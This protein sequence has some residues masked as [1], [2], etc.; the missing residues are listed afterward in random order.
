MNETELRAYAKINLSLTVTGRRENGYHNIR[1]LMQG[2]GLFDVIKLTKCPRNATKY[3]LPHCT[4]GGV[5]VYL[6]TDTETIPVDMSN[7]AFRGAAAVIDAY[8][9]QIQDDLMISIDKR[10]P[11]AAGIAGGSGNAAVCMLGLN[12][13][14][15][16]PFSLRELMDIGGRIDSFEKWI[17][18][19]TETGEKAEQEGELLKAATCY[20]AAQ[21]Y[22]LSG[23]KDSDGRN[24]KHKSCFGYQMVISN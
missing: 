9:R 2:I 16:S 18:L 22:T 21:F 4:I 7:L 23:E 20:R 10:L 19:F 8:E 15:G 13:L 3:K 5:V 24:L 1:S 12:S 17:S 14:L 6:C 11:V